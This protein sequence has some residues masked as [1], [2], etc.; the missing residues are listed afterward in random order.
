MAHEIPREDWYT[1]EDPELRGQIGVM[2]EVGM[3]VDDRNAARVPEGVYKVEHPGCDYSDHFTDSDKINMNK[4]LDLWD[5]VAGDDETD[6]L[7]KEDMKEFSGTPEGGD[8]KDMFDVMHPAAA[9]WGRIGNNPEGSFTRKEWEMEYRNV[10]KPLGETYII[11]VDHAGQFQYTYVHEI[12]KTTTI[13]QLKKMIMQPIGPGPD[14]G[15]PVDPEKVR[16]KRRHFIPPR[17]DLDPDYLHLS[18]GVDPKLE[19]DK[20]CVSYGIGLSWAKRFIELTGY[21]SPAVQE[22]GSRNA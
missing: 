12:T 22:W 5:M 13:G 6:T 9:I 14:K 19:D 11:H 20:T 4:A 21:Q 2:N 1:K 8:I 16:S 7:T 15:F 3:W 17:P 10:Q 18:T